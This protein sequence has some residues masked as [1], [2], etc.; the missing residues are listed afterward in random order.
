[1]GEGNGRDVAAATARLGRAFDGNDAYDLLAA[2]TLASANQIPS[3]HDRLSA[4][5][6]SAVVE[7]AHGFA[8]RRSRRGPSTPSEEPQSLAELVDD[9]ELAAARSLLPLGLDDGAL[10][11]LTSD[12][13]DAQAALRIWQLFAHDPGPF[14]YEL[15]RVVV[16]LGPFAD[17]LTMTLG[18]TATQ[19]TAIVLSF[20]VL[21]T[22]GLRNL[23]ELESEGGPELRDELATLIGSGKALDRVPPQLG[24]H[25]SFDAG[26]IGRCVRAQGIELPDSALAAFLERFSLPFGAIPPDRDAARALWDVRERPLLRDDDGFYLWTVPYNLAFAI[27]PV[28][29]RAL[30]DVGGAVATAYDKEKGAALEREALMT[31]HN[32]LTVDGS[33][34]TLEYESDRHPGQSVEGDGLVALD[35]VALTVESKAVELSPSA[36]QGS[37]KALAKKLEDAIVKGAAQGARTRTALLGDE[38]VTGISVGEER[39]E[40]ITTTELSRVMPVV[41]V[42]EPLGAVTSALWRLIKLSEP[43][44]PWPWVVNIDDLRWF[45]RE[46]ELPIRL[47][48]YAV[49]RQRIAASG[50]L[51]AIDEADWFWM[52]YSQGAA[53]VQEKLELMK[54][55]SAQRTQITGPD[56]RRGSPLPGRVIQL[57]NE[58]LLIDLH[59]DR[60]SGWVE[61]AFALLDLPP[62]RDRHL[63]RRLHTALRQPSGSATWL[64]EVPAFEGGSSLVVGVGSKGLVDAEL[65]IRMEAAREDAIDAGAA[66]I[67]GLAIGFGGDQPATCAWVALDETH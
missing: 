8:L 7:Y 23:F 60:P 18:F 55:V 46:L 15:E 10:D 52:Y 24:A 41:V 22:I 62:E 44:D 32:G 6:P 43:T 27:R 59:R 40:T 67:C 57:A 36:R 56:V 65:T 26:A 17:E 64:S 35:S 11:G 21:G 54:L 19:A 39:R 25:V 51:G 34:G 9:A 49:V 28:C 31:L 16:A 20:D 42:L 1:M 33:W 13:R 30:R 14:A 63:A 66:R 48:H 47:L 5:L 29:E 12:E 50:R 45:A 3:R 58:E 61:V 38:V 4:K 2:L 37:A 53:A